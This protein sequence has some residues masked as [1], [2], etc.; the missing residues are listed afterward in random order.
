MGKYY[1]VYKGKTANSKIY[2]TWEE[3]KSEVHGCKGAIYK[4]FKTKEE[5]LEYFKVFENGGPSK[6]SEITNGLTIYVDG[7]FSLEKAN[8]SYGL[9]ALLDGEEI[10][11]EY[12]AGEDID[13]VPLRNV[14]GEVLGAL[15][16]VE[17][18]IKNN[19][20]EVTIFYD[21]Q[22]IENW[23]L[24]TWNRN[25]KLTIDYY[26][27]MQEFIK[28]I[29]INFNKVKGHSGDKYNDAVDKLAKKAL[30]IIS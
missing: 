16:A 10:Y 13:A 22:G 25:K 15:K 4:S 11:E 9:I 5:A 20:K 24:G 29:K 18:A 23:A 7:S 27:K 19:H 3:C 14:A 21:Y 17:Y 6:E 2:S 28:V 12:G 8:Y 26:N 30:G 1:A